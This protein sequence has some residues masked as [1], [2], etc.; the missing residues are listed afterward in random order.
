MSWSFW[1]REYYEQPLKNPFI[2][3]KAKYHKETLTLRPERRSDYIPTELYNLVDDDFE[4]IVSHR[5][6]R[7]KFYRINEKVYKV[8]CHKH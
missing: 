2:R 6:N 4:E 5:F 3:V 8:R 7:S 1:L